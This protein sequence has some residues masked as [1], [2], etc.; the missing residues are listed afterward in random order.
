VDEQIKELTTHLMN[1]RLEVNT[2]STKMDAIKDMQTK[3]DDHGARMIAVEAS[4]ASAH[5]RLNAMT[6]IVTSLSVGATLAVISAVIT[7]IVKGGLMK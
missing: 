4:S 5:H 1:L 7:F 6:R 3:V 2:I